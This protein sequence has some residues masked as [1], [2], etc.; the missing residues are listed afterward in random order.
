[1]FLSTKFPCHSNRL[2]ALVYLDTVTRYMKF[3]LENNQYISAALCVFLDERGI[4]HSNAI[5]SRR[6]SY[7]FM[8]VVKLL[9][10]KLIPYIETI[11]QVSRCFERKYQ[12]H[13][14]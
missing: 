2:V 6:A 1:M 12:L 8:R 4:H 11:L 10:A 13:S 9:K 7:L 5:V 14:C 3:V